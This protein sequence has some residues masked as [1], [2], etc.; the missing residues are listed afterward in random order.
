MSGHDMH[1]LL[2]AYLD[3][4]LFTFNTEFLVFTELKIASFDR[5]AF[6][7]TVTGC[8]WAGCISDTG[9][10]KEETYEYRRCH[11]TVPAPLLSSARARPLTGNDTRWAPR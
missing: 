3:E 4:L 2:F 1:S 7:I 8:A 9:T 10:D 5:E 11:L 6:S